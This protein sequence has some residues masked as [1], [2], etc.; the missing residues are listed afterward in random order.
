MGSGGSEYIM[1]PGWRYRS[2]GN[3]EYYPEENKGYVIDL[4]W[5]HLVEDNCVYIMNPSWSSP[6]DVSHCKD[7]EEAKAY[8]VAL[9]RMG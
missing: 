7:L 4:Y 1:S 2:K 5:K 6:I 9:W 3:Y 8:A